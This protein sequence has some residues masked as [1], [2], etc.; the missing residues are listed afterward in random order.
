MTKVHGILGCKRDRHRNHKVQWSYH[1]SPIRRCP[2][3]VSFQ[4]LIFAIHPTTKVRGL[5]CFSYFNLKL[6]YCCRFPFFVERSGFAPLK[7]PKQH[8]TYHRADLST[9]YCYVSPLVSLKA[10]EDIGFEPMTPCL[11]SKCSSQLS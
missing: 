5:S 11:Q 1:H 6:K 7:L 8:S 4:I 3:E 2:Y 9:P 10:V